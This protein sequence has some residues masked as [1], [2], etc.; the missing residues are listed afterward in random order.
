MRFILASILTFILITSLNAQNNRSSLIKTETVETGKGVLSDLIHPEK[1][2]TYTRLFLYNLKKEGFIETHSV[3]EK[4]KKEYYIRNINGGLYVGALITIND[5]INES[6]L[7][8]SGVLIGTKAGNIWSVKIPI[9]QLS[10]IGKINGLIYIE[11][12]TP[13]MPML[14][15]AR[16]KTWTNWVHNGYQLPQAYTG[17]DVVVGVIDK[18]MDPSHTAFHVATGINRIKRFWKMGDNTGTPPA[19]YGYGSEIIGSS[20][21]MWDFD[22]ND[23]S[24]GTHV[25]STAAGGGGGTSVSSIYTGI[26]PESDIVMVAIEGSQSQMLD[27]INYIFNYANSVNKPATVNLSWG[28]HMGPHDG[29]SYF[30][31]AVGNLVGQGKVVV[32][33]AGNS[34]NVHHH[35]TKNFSST[36]NTVNSFLYFPT[37]TLKTNGISTIDIW[38]DA[39]SS[40]EVSINLYN[41]TS[42]SYEDFTPYISTNINITQPYTLAD[43]DIITDYCYVEVAMTASHPDNQKPRAT[44]T[45]DNTDQDDNYRFVLLEIRNNNNSR[46]DAWASPDNTPV[47]NRTY[48][49]NLSRTVPSNLKDGDYSSTIAEI[50]GTGKDI[51]TV[52]SYTSK[53]TWTDFQGNPRNLTT[54]F[55][56]DLDPVNSIASSSSKGPTIDGRT[57]PDIT[58]PGNVIVAA[59]NSFNNVGFSNTTPAVVY[60]EQNSSNDVWRWA[61]MGGTSMAAPVVTGI[62]ALM[63]EADPT[64]TASEIKMLIKNN[65]FTDTHTG[66]VPNY[67]WGWGKVDAHESVK[68][69]ALAPSST[70][71]EISND[72]MVYPNPVKEVV[73]IQFN[74]NVKAKILLR[75]LNGNILINE[76]NDTNKQGNLKVLNLNRI[77]S[78][79]YILTIEQEKGVSNYKI[80]KQ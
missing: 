62:T 17:K 47:R 7:K 4:L 51:I 2:S 38:G 73:N 39:G 61:V 11:I 22:V 79:I 24:H 37:T 6:T 45:I 76:S 63:L 40:F 60:A 5:K 70:N 21:I 13:A 14:D 49:E 25:T 3:S 55:G 8:S 77:S 43:F 54:V 9:N 33:S 32:G 53:N 12:D 64:L 48:F 46:I 27:G 28:S 68:A 56:W 66:S 72:I 1:Y 31:V 59:V 80:I 58:A 10:N 29:T 65:A 19:G 34:G 57:K 36:N 16:E 44:I 75:S 23:N 50:G 35:L 67:T 18:G 69:V 74:T 15:K 52:G 71:L 20:S 41:I 26:A 78:G 42:N 30:D